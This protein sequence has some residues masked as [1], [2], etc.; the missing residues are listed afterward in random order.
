MKEIGG[1][2]ELELNHGKEY[3][4]DAIRLNLGR[5]AFEYVLRVKKIKKIFIPYYTC[6]IMLEPVNLTGVNFEFYH[7]DKNLEPVFNYKSLKDTDYFLY[8]NY[9]G[10]KDKFI[11]TLTNKISNL[12]I[13]NSQAFYSKPLPDVDTFYSPR[14]FFGVPDGGYLYTKRILDKNLEIDNSS[15]RFTHLIGRIEENAE[16]FY[17]IFRDN[18]QKLCGQSIKKMS[19]I[20][21]RLLSNI[22]YH[23]IAQ[24]RKRN[25]EYLHKKLVNKNCFKLE[26]NG[27]FVPM[28]YPFL[29]ENKNLKNH[30]IK[31]KLFVACYWPN[32]INWVAKESIEYKFALQMIPLPIDQRYNL[33]DMSIIS[34][35]II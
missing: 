11:N 15:D 18:D 27:F 12:I 28:I 26:L 1:Y 7:I 19:N 5:A 17:P 4:C 13:D 31:N 35:L 29:S 3:H 23:K 24:I 6:D 14:K 16:K 33:N 22:N 25:F 2:F 34:K 20:T 30:L 8:T 21:K 9:F 32:V 10:L